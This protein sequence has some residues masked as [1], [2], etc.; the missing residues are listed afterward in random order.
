MVNPADAI[1]RCFHS[2]GHHY[3]NE[4]VKYIISLNSFIYKYFPAPF[5][6]KPCSKDLALI[7][8]FNPLYASTKSGA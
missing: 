8:C 3:I 2:T 7:C 6:Y 1:V 5:I 4:Y